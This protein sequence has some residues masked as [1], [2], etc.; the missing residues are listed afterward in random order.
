[1]VINMKYVAIIFIIALFILSGCNRINNSVEDAVQIHWK[2]PIEIVNQDEEKQLVYYLNNTQHILG[3]YHYEN[4]KYRYNNE[5]TIG[6]S[7]NRRVDY[8]F[9][10]QLINLK[11]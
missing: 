7:L 5:Q 10:Y 11:V 2:T 3:V 8:L 9:C 6:Y 4:G 1:M